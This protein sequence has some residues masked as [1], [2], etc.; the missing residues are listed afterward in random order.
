M[1]NIR[2]EIEYKENNICVCT[3]YNKM[4]IDKSSNKQTPMN[5]T[6]HANIETFE[7]EDQEVGSNIVT[8]DGQHINNRFEDEQV[9]I[10]E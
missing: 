6:L 1:K 8:S 10:Y 4:S 2:V 3:H 9:C 7:I 5:R